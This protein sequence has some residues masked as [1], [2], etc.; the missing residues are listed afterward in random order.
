MSG[1]FRL[2]PCRIRKRPKISEDFTNVSLSEKTTGE[3]AK[4][5]PI[6]QLLAVSYPRE[7]S[8][9]ARTKTKN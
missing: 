2:A 7:K 3:S 1:R 8:P 5:P 4:L 9:G 6:R